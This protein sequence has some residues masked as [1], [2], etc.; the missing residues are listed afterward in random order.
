MVQHL[1]KVPLFK[2]VMKP[3]EAK[4]IPVYNKS[5]KSKQCDHHNALIWSIS[6]LP[7]SPAGNQ[8][9]WH[10]SAYLH[11]IPTTILWGTV[12]FAP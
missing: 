11:F 7:S 9:G 4:M 5:L 6:I 1:K 10:N 12:F 8:S 3:E 2:M